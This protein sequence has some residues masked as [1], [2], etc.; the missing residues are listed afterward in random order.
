MMKKTYFYYLAALCAG[1]LMG[2]VLMPSEKSTELLHVVEG[3]HDVEVN[4]AALT[5]DSV[6]TQIDFGMGH[7]SESPLM[8][9]VLQKRPDMVKRCLA[10]GADTEARYSVEYYGETQ[11]T[12][13]HAAVKQG[14]LE[15]VQLLVQGGA[16]MES[17]LYR[18]IQYTVPGYTP[19]M[20]AV[21]LGF[22]DIA[23]YL[24]EQGADATAVSDAS[25]QL[26]VGAAAES[27]LQVSLAHADC[28]ELVR[29]HL[30]KTRPSRLLHPSYEWGCFSLP[31]A[32]L[33]RPIE[34]FTSPDAAAPVMMTKADVLKHLNS[35]YCILK[36]NSVTDYTYLIGHDTCELNR[37]FAIAEVLYSKEPMEAVRA[38]YL[39]Y[40]RVECAAFNAPSK[41]EYPAE[42]VYICLKKE[43]FAR[44]GKGLYINFY[45]VWDDTV[46][47]AGKDVTAIW[48]DLLQ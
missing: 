34:V 23:R 24:L 8:Y 27:V 48:Q 1:V 3:T 29:E 9:A 19:L 32:A 39:H 2:Y 25:L 12:P 16:D 36:V 13:L 17:L 14:N 43:A 5:R 15:I 31:D 35:C 46:Y 21:E 44:L 42:D 38:V 10:L 20:R 47:L 4:W 26:E 18:D 37:E 6:N 33:H 28:Y 7:T 41:K 30:H 40:N 45:E 11:A 22:T